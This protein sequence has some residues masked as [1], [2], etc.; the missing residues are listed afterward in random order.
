M[1]SVTLIRFVSGAFAL[2]VLLPLYFSPTILGRKTNQAGKIFLLNL[3]AGWT[4]IGWFAAL[5]LAVKPD[6][7][8]AKIV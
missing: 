7:P 1:D 6:Q 4:V 5:S 3:F 8:Q 2:C